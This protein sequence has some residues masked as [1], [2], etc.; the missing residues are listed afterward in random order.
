MTDEEIDRAVHRTV[1]E[2]FMVFGID[3]SDSASVREFQSDLGYLRRS[4]QGSEELAKWAKRSAVGA[5]ITALCVLLWEGLKHAM[6][7]GG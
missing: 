4:R 3:T 7:R 2:T 5:G 1:Q 6:T